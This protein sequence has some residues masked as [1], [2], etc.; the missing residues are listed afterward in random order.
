MKSNKGILLIALGNEYAKLAYNLTKSINKHSPELKIAV[1]TDNTNSDLLEA[2]NVVI[3]PTPIHYLEDGITF[4][5][6]KLK[7]YIYDYSPFDETIYLD[8]DAVCLK[9]IDDLFS[10]FKIQEVGRYDKEALKGSGCVWFNKETDIF[11]LYNLENDYIEYNSSFVSF[12]KSPRNKIYFDKV[13]E[14]YNDRR[15]DYTK[16]GRCYPDEMAFGI[17][18]SLLDHYPTNLHS[19]IAFWW[20]LKN[21]KATLTEITTDY[22]FIGL[23]GGFVKGKLLGYYHS[24]MKQ[25]S[26]HWNFKMSNKIFHQK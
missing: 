18:S 12:K 6:F 11:D 2:F 9:P 25:L 1:I 5:P 23:A 17:A 13:K 21:K 14:L 15:F 24:L 8:V 4:N 19:Y 20:Y 7:T 16:I 3:D 22:Y 26:D 10:D